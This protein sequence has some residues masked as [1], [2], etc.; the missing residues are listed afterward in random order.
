MTAE[1][2]LAQFGV[3]MELAGAFVL[4][5]LGDPATILSISHQFGVTNDML[6]E[7]VSGPLGLPVSGDMVID[8]FG[9][10]G[11][12]STILDPVPEGTG[13][14][15]TPELSDL[16]GVI[17]FNMEAGILS[18]ESLRASV[19]AQTNQADYDLMFDPARFEGSAD[20][21]FTGEELGVPELAAQLATRLTLEALFYGSVINAMRNVDS[22][23]FNALNNFINQNFQAL[24]NRDVAVMV[25]Y[26][27]LMIDIFKDPAPQTIFSNPLMAEFAAVAGVNMVV[28]I[29]LGELPNLFDVLVAHPTFM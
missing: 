9:G 26:S 5:H 28:L 13:Q 20:G 16:A 11:L 17:S 24:E 7:I 3:S 2:H 10:Q 29:G 4:A 27:A 15:L 19:I 14:G 23:E 6:G 22:T 1:E 25:Q 8:W 18:T 21:V 12:D